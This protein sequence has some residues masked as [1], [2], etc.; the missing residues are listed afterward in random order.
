MV[1]PITAWPCIGADAVAQPFARCGDG[2]RSGFLTLLNP[3]HQHVK[4]R[5]QLGRALR[6]VP[7]FVRNFVRIRLHQSRAVACGIHSR[8]ILKLRFNSGLRIV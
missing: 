6:G 5:R 2:Q 1:G 3:L 7:N 4:C 8:A